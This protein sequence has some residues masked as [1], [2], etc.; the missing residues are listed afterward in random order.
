MLD[1]AFGDVLNP[2]APGV[3]E[4]GSFQDTTRNDTG[5]DMS[6][7][8]YNGDG[9]D[10]LLILNQDG[11][12]DSW[13]IFGDS[14]RSNW[15][16]MTQADLDASNSV[17]FT[18]DVVNKQ[19]KVSFLG[20]INGD[21][22]EDIGFSNYSGGNGSVVV[23]LGSSS[24]GSI[25]ISNTAQSNVFKITGDANSDDFGFSMDAAG[26]VNNDGI[27]D[28]IIGDNKSG[29]TY[30]VGSAHVFFGHTGTWSDRSLGSDSLDG[31][32]GFNIIGGLTG[33]T[34]WKTGDSVAGI[35]D[36]NNDGID[37][38]AVGSTVQSGGT[39]IVH[40]VF[41][42]D[43]G[44]ASSI[45]VQDITSAEGMII[46]GDDGDDFGYLVTSAGDFNGDGIDDIA[47]SKYTQGAEK[48]TMND[49]VYVI[50]GSDSLPETLLTSDIDG[51]NGMLIQVADYGASEF[52][53]SVAGG[54]DIDGDGFDDLVI[55]AVGTQ[56]LSNS[57][58]GA[59][60]VIYGNNRGDAS[61]DV[62]DAPA[63]QVS[64]VVYDVAQSTRF[65]QS[66]VIGNFDGDAY[67]D[68]AVGDMSTNS[69]KGGV[70]YFYGIEGNTA[71]T[72]SD[73]TDQTINENEDTGALSFTVGDPDGD[74]ITITATS[75]DTT[76]IP[77]ANIVI[78]GTGANRTVTVTPAAN[79]TGTATITLTVEDSRGSTITD[80]FDVT[81]NDVNNAPAT[82]AISDQT[83]DQDDTTGAIA[84]T[85]SDGD[86]DTVT[87]T[88]VSSNTTLIPNGNIVIAGTGA[89]RT[90]TVT[91]ANGQYGS[92]T[93]TLTLDDGNGGT[94]TETFDVTVNRVN[95]A[96]TISA[97]GNQ[98]INE[99]SD[100]GAIAFTLGD[101]DGDTITVS[102]SSSD[103]TLVPNGNISISGTGANRTVTV[104]PAA[105][106][107][108]T[109]TITLTIDDG[110][111]GTVTETFDV[112]V[113]SVN[114]APT[115]SAVGDQ[116]IDEGTDTG[117]IAFT[118]GDVEGDTVT[119]TGASSDTTL[120]PD[121]NIV[122]A[123]TGA[124]RTV[125]VTPAAG[126]TGTA[127]ITLTLDDGNSGTTTQTFDVTVNAI[128]TTPAV[129]D[130]LISLQQRNETMTKSRTT[131]TIQ[132]TSSVS[133]TN[134]TGAERTDNRNNQDA[135]S[136]IAD[137][138]NMSTF[139][140]A[141]YGQSFVR[142]DYFGN[143]RSSASQNFDTQTQSGT[144]QDLD[145]VTALDRDI[146]GG[147]G[148]EVDAYLRYWDKLYDNGDQQN[149]T[150][151]NTGDRANPQQT[152]VN[153]PDI[154]PRAGEQGDGDIKELP[155]KESRGTDMEG[156]AQTLTAKL[157]HRA[158]AFDRDV[159]QF[160]NSL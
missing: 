44:F 30:D 133:D 92:A 34:G 120:I 18:G 72:I 127:T 104:T 106:Q 152:P 145:I 74:P 29:A 51:T 57:D 33:A 132:D 31:S 144:G 113:N 78:A 53:Y 107:F 128:D 118:V 83:I 27:D 94:T 3:Y 43:D 105:N 141:F 16:D 75:S 24:G 100:T 86:G 2:D 110:F 77:D 23:V 21:G 95:T 138:M 82:T 137:N 36:F 71:P 17:H 19:L 37:D 99:D 11:S 68:F 35:G 48:L 62:V 102:G 129:S 89:N 65:G 159:E 131:E 136:L 122:I 63:A 12:G 58:K 134:D 64:D 20:D 111:G 130:D 56:N 147:N 4:G 109:A 25:D 151:P 149:Q 60:Y 101:A 42:R 146:Y 84:F 26:D 156:Q 10:D 39:G 157:Q 49:G 114:D 90:V 91:P 121:A 148:Q 40:I 73:V 79:Q 66:V 45:N 55:G 32:D 108:G 85:V 5:Q 153:P 28:F 123:G 54:A 76:L 6:V 139:N 14:D 88:G 46:D 70:Y 1:G 9:L 15:G 154:E 140:K 7:G 117:A 69:G 93:I 160:I 158:T 61:L 115:V 124:N 135:L 22:Y 112:T 125:T 150:E 47:V 126:Q 80:T 116:S 13:L 50:Y 67:Y 59:A 119:V 87:V 97:I 96:P 41:G 155:E 98:T 103:T 142:E 38:I 52:G 8:D 143:N 81:V